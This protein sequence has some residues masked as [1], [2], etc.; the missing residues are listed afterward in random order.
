MSDKR[1]EGSGKT[2]RGKTGRK[3]SNYSL[4]PVPGKGSIRLSNAP[5]AE[6]SAAH[7]GDALD[8]TRPVGG[9]SRRGGADLK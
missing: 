2:P 3:A 4:G 6:G 7:A 5:M 8:A 9:P 1:W